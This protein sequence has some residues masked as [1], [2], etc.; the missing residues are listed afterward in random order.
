M[1]VH[2]GMA[3][4]YLVRMKEDVRRGVMDKIKK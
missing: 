3:S 4:Q 1:A 2:F